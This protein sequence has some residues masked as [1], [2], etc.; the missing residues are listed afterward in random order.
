MRSPDFVRQRSSSSLLPS[1]CS[2]ACRLARRRSRVRLRVPRL[3]TTRRTTSPTSASPDVGSFQGRAIDSPL[4]VAHERDVHRAGRPA[5]AVAGGARRR[6]VPRR[7]TPLRGRHGRRSSPSSTCVGMVAGRVV[8]RQSDEHSTTAPSCSTCS[9]PQRRSSTG[10]L[11]AIIAGIGLLARVAGSDGLPGR[12]AS[13]S[14]SAGLVSL[15]MLVADS[16][17]SVIDLLPDG[18]W[19]RAPCT[20]IDRVGAALAVSP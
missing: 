2:R 18:V 16:G 4:H 5:S 9:A 10:N 11:V 19:E 13:P 6:G 1:G 3:R 8:P 20:P 14:G 7:V 17:S 15:V 12:R